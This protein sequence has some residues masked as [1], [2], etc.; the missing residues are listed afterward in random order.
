MTTFDQDIQRRFSPQGAV[1]YGDAGEMVQRAAIL[2][3]KTNIDAQMEVQEN[4]WEQRDREYAQLMERAY[5][6]TPLAPI[7]A[8]NFYTGQRPSLVEAPLER[9]PNVTARCEEAQA[10]GQQADQ[11]DTFSMSLF[12]EVLCAVGPGPDPNDPVND[13]HD[14]EDQIDRQSHRL[15]A[16]VHCAI[17][18]DPSLGGMIHPIQNPPTITPSLLWT[19]KG[20]EAPGSGD[21]YYF[22]GKQLKYTVTSYA[23]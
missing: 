13:D 11:Y 19:R 10:F 16:A 6:K 14:L 20:D 23:L 4:L 8:D 17:R 12:V 9:W 18:L 22:Q 1:D 15:T 7:E 5:V 21:Y 3:I 2:Q